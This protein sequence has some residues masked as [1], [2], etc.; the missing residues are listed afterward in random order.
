MI[1]P[2]LVSEPDAL[3]EYSVDQRP[4]DV[5]QGLPLKNRSS[6][7]TVKKSKAGNRSANVGLQLTSNPL[8]ASAMALP[9]NL[10][11]EVPFHALYIHS[12]VI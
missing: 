2:Y 8:I 10:C 12:F 9:I 11:S 5:W 3:A 4:S 6:H 1:C 7:N